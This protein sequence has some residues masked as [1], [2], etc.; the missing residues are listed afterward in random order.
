MQFKDIKGYQEVKERLINSVKSGNV[1]HAQLFEGSKGSGALPLAIAYY[2]YLNCEKPDEDSCGTCSSC[3]KIAKHIHP[4]IHFV[5]PVSTSKNV[6]GSNLISKN[7]LKEWRNF[8][9]DHPY[10]ELEDWSNYYG[11]EN[12]QAL[13][14]RQEGR[15]IV[16]D[17]SL[18]AFEAKYKVI[19]IW[20]PEMMHI[21]A[22]NSILK[23]LEEP[24]DS[25]LFILVSNDPEKI[26]S[27]ILSR[28][29]RISIRPFKE[30]EIIEIIKER[31]VDENQAIQIAHLSEGNLNLATRL[32][33]NLED[34]NQQLFQDWMRLCFQ[35]DFAKLVSW[36]EEFS[37][38]NKVAQKSLLS[39][40][41]NILRE[42]LV[43]GL[44]GGKLTR[45]RNK[46]IEFVEN[47]SKVLDSDKIEL[48]NQHFNDAHYFLERNANPR[49]LFM[50][51]SIKVARLFN[52]N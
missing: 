10:G 45:A 28:V 7:Y 32:S 29:Q 9:Q 16:K 36:S 2:T 1:A 39:Y 50:D 6:K 18:K 30:N 25:T 48:L 17:L 12:R 13:I 23:V 34:D 31:G 27:T 4:D 42:T 5:F 21:S 24:S 52:K 19:L 43:Y 46:E 37:R 49:I 8:L 11:G 51:I 3:D 14:S 35:S 20:L 47:F 41:M 44:N 26:I 15:E 38:S 22:A 33:E 40:G